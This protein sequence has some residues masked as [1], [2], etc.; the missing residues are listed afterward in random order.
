MHKKYYYESS[1]IKNQSNK[2]EALK[3]I[4]KYKLTYIIDNTYTSNVNLRKAST[5]LQKVLSATADILLKSLQYLKRNLSANSQ[6][7]RQ[8]LA[9]AIC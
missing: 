1:H 4:S 7:C 2:F 9:V 6:N 5:V 8:L 3:D